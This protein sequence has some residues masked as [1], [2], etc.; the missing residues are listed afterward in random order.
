MWGSLC[1]C[2]CVSNSLS[3]ALSVCVRGRT[4]R[5]RWFLLY[6]LLKNPQLVL[7]RSPPPPSTPPSRRPSLDPPSP[8]PSLDPPSYALGFHNGWSGGVQTAS[9]GTVDGIETDA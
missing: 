5:Q 7:L 9:D 6:T 8:R 2:V 3:L 4:V 1:V